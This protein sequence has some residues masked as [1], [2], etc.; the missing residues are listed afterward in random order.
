MK[1]NENL[2]INKALELES[3]KKLQEVLSEGGNRY[4]KHIVLRKLYEHDPENFLRAVE[5]ITSEPVVGLIK[6]GNGVYTILDTYLKNADLYT[7]DPEKLVEA[8]KRQVDKPKEVNNPGNLLY[9]AMQQLIF[10]QALFN[11]Q[12]LLSRK[13]PF[14]LLLSL[15]GGTMA[16]DPHIRCDEPRRNI[17]PNQRPN[18]NNNVVPH[19]EREHEEVVSRD[20]NDVI[21]NAGFESQEEDLYGDSPEKENTGF[22]QRIEN[23]R[24]NKQPNQQEQVEDKVPELARVL[25]GLHQFGNAPTPGNLWRDNVPVNRINPPHGNLLGNVATPINRPN[26]PNQQPNNNQNNGNQGRGYY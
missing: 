26:N 19:N 21:K 5:V 22:V 7:K 25:S 3:V 12:S 16:I 23:E 18:V 6:E 10:M 20:I 1:S 4:F 13:S 15:M 11:P 14:S 2:A 9:T 24:N 8:V 17:Q